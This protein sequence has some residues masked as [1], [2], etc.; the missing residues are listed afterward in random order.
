MS[1]REL[2]ALTIVLSPTS[3]YFLAGA[4]FTLMF[5]IAMGLKQSDFAFLKSHKR[6]FWGGLAGQIVALPLA[7]IALAMLLQ[8]APSIALGMIVIAA[9][10]GGNVSNFMTDMAGGD[11]AYSVSLTAGSSV[12]ASLWTPFAIL[13]WSD[14]YQPTGALL[15]TIN[16]NRAGFIAQ[17][18]ALLALP[19]TLGMTVRAL[20]PA[21]ADRLKAPLALAGAFV[22]GS[23]IIT[24]MAEF[25]P[26]LLGAWALIMVPVIAHN[27]VAFG[28]GAA[29]GRLLGTT[30][31]RRRSLTFE[32][33]IQNTGLAVVLLLS[34]LNG[35]GGAAAIAVVWGVWHFF[36]GG[37]M[38]ALYRYL[39][40]RRSTT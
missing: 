25:V 13:F 3:Q 27:T 12:I 38:I 23:V 32:I 29:T 10:P 22:L 30:P 28:L 33:G 40:H 6:L 18:V 14:L 39:D 4:L 35:L 34:Q 37:A 8:P 26:I 1:E 36:S 31:R 5:A 16:F 17:T 24:G 15:E 7:T 21:L 19:L 9:C 2:D 20:R 11:T